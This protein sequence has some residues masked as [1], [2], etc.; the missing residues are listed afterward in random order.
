MIRV[1]HGAA[2]QDDITITFPHSIENI[3]DGGSFS[4]PND[5]KIDLRAEAVANPGKLCTVIFKK[6]PCTS[7]TQ[8]TYGK[9]TANA[10][11][12]VAIVQDA[13]Q[14]SL[15]TWKDLPAGSKVDVPQNGAYDC[16]TAAW[17]VVIA[18]LL[19]NNIQGDIQ[20]WPL[21]AAEFTALLNSS[22]KLHEMIKQT[23]DA[24]YFE[25]SGV[26]SDFVDGSIEVSTDPAK[27]QRAEVP[28]ECGGPAPAGEDEK[29][30]RKWLYAGAAVL[31]LGV[32]GATVA[33]VRRPKGPSRLKSNP[34]HKLPKPRRY[35][36]AEL[37]AY[38]TLIQGHMDDC[39][40]EDK[41]NGHKYRVWLSRMTKEDGMP[42]DNQVSVEMLDDNFNWV[43]ID[44]Y[45][46][47]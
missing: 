45:R 15:V 20:G 40:V 46:A 17:M 36:L 38:K 7:S 26:Q 44:T 39:K 19:G 16:K 8:C 28:H 42:Y 37:E 30:N 12:L 32:V 47:R 27:F 1:F 22:A 5:T 9:I 31:T 11:T 33:L 2:P 14:T 41:L 10:R 23:V 3:A 43:E 35:S 21:G 13:M 25:D 18:Q 4:A 6:L 34:A 29:L 24:S